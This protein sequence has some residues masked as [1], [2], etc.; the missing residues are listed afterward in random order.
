MRI[1][2]RRDNGHKAVI[3]YPAVCPHCRKGI[4]LDIES[5]EVVEIQVSKI[6][7]VGGWVSD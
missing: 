3:F 4:Y 5:E 2:A 7:R 6:K 1:T